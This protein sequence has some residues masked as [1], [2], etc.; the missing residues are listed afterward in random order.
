MKAITRVVLGLALAALAVKAVFTLTADA[1]RR[2]THDRTALR[3]R[4][5]DIQREAA[6]RRVSG[7]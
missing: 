5:A 6:R 2:L 3:L 7:R 1:R 4:L